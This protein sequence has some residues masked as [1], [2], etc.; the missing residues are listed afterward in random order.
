MNS[1]D[2]FINELSSRI[3]KLKKKLEGT[4]KQITVMF[5]EHD[6]VFESMKEILRLAKRI[7]KT[8]EKNNVSI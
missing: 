4:E 2:V 6:A 3:E 7:K 1:I 5:A 8:T